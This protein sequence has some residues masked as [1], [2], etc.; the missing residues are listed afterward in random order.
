M[1]QYIADRRNTGVE[2]ENTVSFRPCVPLFVLKK[3]ISSEQGNLLF[4]KLHLPL[5][6]LVLCKLLKHNASDKTCQGSADCAESQNQQNLSRRV[7]GKRS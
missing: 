6:R 2:A 1:Q 4:S 7:K 3:Q 5:L